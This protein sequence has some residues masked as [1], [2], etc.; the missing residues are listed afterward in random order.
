M[1]WSLVSPL[2]PLIS[3]FSNTYGK[4]KVDEKA[5]SRRPSIFLLEDAERQPGGEGVF[6]SSNQ[7]AN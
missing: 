3:H 7:R 2:P 4:E 6:L 1:I 5:D